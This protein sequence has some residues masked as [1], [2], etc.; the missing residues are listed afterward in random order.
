MSVDWYLVMKFLI[1]GSPLVLV[2][3]V[4]YAVTKNTDREMERLFGDVIPPEK[5]RNTVPPR[6]PR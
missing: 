6:L 2:A 4:W 1:A 5:P 3:A